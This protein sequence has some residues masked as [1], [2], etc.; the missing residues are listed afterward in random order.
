MDDGR[1]RIRSGTGPAG[2]AMVTARVLG[3]NMPLLGHVNLSFDLDTV[4]A[5]VKKGMDRFH[6]RIRQEFRPT[7]RSAP[8]EYAPSE[9]P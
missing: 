2:P 8:L 5:Y 1:L 9:N 4:M 3:V 7:T 6:R